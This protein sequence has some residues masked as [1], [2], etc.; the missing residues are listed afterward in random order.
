MPKDT[1]DQDISVNLLDRIANLTE[2]NRNFLEQ[3][4]VRQ[5]KS[6]KAAE[7]GN[8]RSNEDT[9]ANFDLEGK[10]AT[11]ALLG[12]TFNAIVMAPVQII[13]QGLNPQTQK[14]MRYL[15]GAVEGIKAIVGAV[16]TS[17]D[18]TDLLRKQ[19]VFMERSGYQ[20]NQP[21]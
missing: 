4:A 1:L 7:Y 11:R 16:N 19:Q 8:I 20:P 5:E 10:K 14:A 13:S 17:L 21:S 18:R 2:A 3:D 12:T 9:Y 15:T 6:N